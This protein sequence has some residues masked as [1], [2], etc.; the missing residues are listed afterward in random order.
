MDEAGQVHVRAKRE[1]LEA[2]KRTKH[3]SAYDPQNSK[4]VVIVGGGPAGI[5]CAESLRQEG[6]TG[7]IVMACKEEAVTYDRTLVSK[8]L[9]FDQEKMALRPREFYDRHN[10]EMKLG[11][12]AIGMY[13]EGNGPRLNRVLSHFN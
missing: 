6:F 13:N 5:T 1:D 10:I 12:E 3:M 2:N 7:R 8:K 4:T 9:D 11:V